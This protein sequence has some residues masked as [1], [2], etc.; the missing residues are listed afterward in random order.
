M[1]FGQI[2]VSHLTG[3]GTRAYGLANNF[4]ALSNDQSGLFWNPAGL[5]FVPAREFQF[6]FDGLSQRTN[7]D[8]FDQSGTSVVQRLR[9]V[10]IGYLHAFPTTQGGL[11]IAGALQ[12]PYTFDDVRDF[13]GSYQ[14]NGDK[15]VYLSRN[16]KNYGGLSYWTGGFGLQVAEGLGIGVSA[17]FVTGSAQGE[18]IFY[19][20]TNGILGDSLNDSYD[21]K[22]SRTYLGYD[23]RFGLLYNFS[24]HFNIGLRF[25]LP[26]TIWFTQDISET[27]PNTDFGEYDY[28]TANGKIFSSYS[29]AI[30]FSGTFPFMTFSTEFRARS[31]YTLAYPSENIPSSSLAAKTIFGAG[32]GVEAPVFV[33]TVLLRAGYSWDQYDTHLFALQYDDPQLNYPPGQPNWDSQGE[34]PVGDEH[35]IT[36]GIAYIMKNACLEISY[37]YNFWQLETNDQ[38]TEAHTQNRVMTSLSFRF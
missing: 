35:L 23:I 13:S 10:N 32:V 26:Q 2:D 24:K 14:T 28:P 22:I 18:N 6:G 1:S 33:S 25:V 20:D 8:F 9:L 37:G 7:T 38:L 17:S 15:T 5:A 30:G 36:V 12:N 11:T 4:V 19:R 27:N 16:Y 34:A 21:D 29:G 31:P 3:V